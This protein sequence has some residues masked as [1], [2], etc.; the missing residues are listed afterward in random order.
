MNL[1]MNSTIIELSVYAWNFVLKVLHREEPGARV[2]PKLMLKLQP[3]IAI[4]QNFSIFTLHNFQ[5]RTTV[6]FR[7]PIIKISWEKFGLLWFIE[8]LEQTLHAPLRR[9]KMNFEHNSGHKQTKLLQEAL[10][11]YLV[12]ENELSK[13]NQFRCLEIPRLTLKLI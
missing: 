12:S 8:F 1:T 5:T 13:R 7:H 9:C 10:I 11:L 3:N 4:F 6:Y 2:W